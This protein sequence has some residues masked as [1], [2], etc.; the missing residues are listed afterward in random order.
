M[1]FKFYDDAIANV[2]KLSVERL[3]ASK[4]R[5]AFLSHCDYF[6]QT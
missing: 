5:Q 3:S 2:P 4:D 6:V 1:S